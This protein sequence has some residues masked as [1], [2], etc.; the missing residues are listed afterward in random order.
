MERVDEILRF[1][2]G[3]SPDTWRMPEDRLSMWFGGEPEVDEAIRRR[4]E[5][6][7]EEALGGGLDGWKETPRGRLALVLLLDQ[8][9]RN[10]YRGTPEAY[11]GDPL[12]LP[13]ALESLDEGI[14]RELRPV[15]RPF[16]YLPLEHAEDRQVQ[17]ASVAAF[18]RLADEAPEEVR[19]AYE[20]FLDYAIRHQ[21]I[22]DRFG[23]FPHRNAILGRQTTPEEAEFLKQPGSS[24]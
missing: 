4:F 9:T 20:V 24:F 8:F 21:V 10:V 22:V 17:A 23:R 11:A 7:V 14:D 12:A 5:S 3:D 2:F 13:L 1:W 16:L 6:T 15:A 18:R 19:A